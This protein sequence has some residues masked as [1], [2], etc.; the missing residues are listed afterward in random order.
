MAIALS[1]PGNASDMTGVPGNTKYV[2][3]TITHSGAYGTGASLTATDLGL[4][5]IHI[6]LFSA[7]GAA[8]ANTAYIAQYDYTNSVLRLY[9]SSGNETALEEVGSSVTV[10]KVFRVMAYGR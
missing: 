4:E 1:T 2:V 9:I 6:L 10:A 8:G 3:K 7:E 5:S